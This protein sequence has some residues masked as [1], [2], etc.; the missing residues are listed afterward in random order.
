MVLFLLH[1]PVVSISTSSQHSA[2]SIPTRISADLEKFNASLWFSRNIHGFFWNCNTKVHQRFGI[3]GETGRNTILQKLSRISFLAAGR[4]YE[5]CATNLRTPW[6]G[7]NVNE[8]YGE[9]RFGTLHW[10]SGSGYVHRWDSIYPNRSNLL[11]KKTR[12]FHRST[13]SLVQPPT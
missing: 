8:E 2:R 11:L 10:Q 1:H 6:P 3:Y 5:H 13:Q 7:R 12:S 4:I 9:R